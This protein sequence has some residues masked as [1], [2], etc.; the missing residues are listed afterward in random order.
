MNGKMRAGVAQVG[1][2]QANCAALGVHGK[3]WPDELTG[4]GG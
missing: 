1:T 4:S 3:I 2:L